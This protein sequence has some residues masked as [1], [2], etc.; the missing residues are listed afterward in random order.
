MECKKWNHCD[1][2][3]S[4]Y[5]NVLRIKT[6][7]SCRSCFDVSHK[8]IKYNRSR[9]IWTIRF[10]SHWY[11]QARSQDTPCS[12]EC[13]CAI[14]NQAM[15]SKS[16]RFPDE[17]PQTR[18]LTKQPCNS[19]QMKEK[20]WIMKTCAAK[21][22]EIDPHPSPFM[23][24]LFKSPSS[25]HKYATEPRHLKPLE[26]RKNTSSG[27]YKTQHNFLMFFFQISKKL[28]PDNWK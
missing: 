21:E 23:A 25:S 2:Q 7:V 14:V 13:N 17:E 24:G 15:R 18:I 11:S 28:A 26:Q 9:F 20:P 10:Q 4:T 5:I 12:W 6:K 22:H 8:Q 19:I 16:L 3:I 27:P 1:C